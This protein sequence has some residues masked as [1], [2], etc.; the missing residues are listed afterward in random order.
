MKHLSLIIAGDWKKRNQEFLQMNYKFY[1]IK[2]SN[3]TVW[4]GLH[5]VFLQHGTQVREL[6]I[7]DCSMLCTDFANIVSGLPMLESIIFQK[8]QFREN[9]TGF[10]NVFPLLNNLKSIE[11]TNSSYIVSTGFFTT[12]VFI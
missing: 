9:M 5:D 4:D 3:L 1:K 10:P 8:V 12:L 6:K 11:V 2:L 7:S